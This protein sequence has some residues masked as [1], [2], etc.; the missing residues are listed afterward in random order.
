MAERIAAMRSAS[1]MAAI[2][3]A[4]EQFEQERRR[5]FPYLPSGLFF[6]IG[7]KLQPARIDFL[8]SHFLGG[9][10]SERMHLIEQS[11]IESATEL[12]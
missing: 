4:T 9:E 6:V 3:T 12:P 8:R 11:D 2:Q 10:A 5:S 1:Y 7:P